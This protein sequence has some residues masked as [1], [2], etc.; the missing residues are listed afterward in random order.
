MLSKKSNAGG[1]TIPDFKLSYRAIA[2]KTAW[3][4]HRNGY[5]DQWNRI[6][7]LNL[8]PHSLTHLI[9]EQKHTMEKRQSLQQ[10][11]LGKLVCLQKTETRSMFVTLY[12]CQLKSR[13]RI[14]TLDLK[15]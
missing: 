9:F 13:L 1:I 12:K 2:I 4:W 8:N 6:E 3:Y 11:F 14:F 7:D 5:E 15:P 10:M